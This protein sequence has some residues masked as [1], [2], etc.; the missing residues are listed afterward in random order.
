V[1]GMLFMASK[2]VANAVFLFVQFIIDE[3]YSATGVAKYGFDPLLYK[4]LD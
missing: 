1:G 4:S 2:Y 3:K